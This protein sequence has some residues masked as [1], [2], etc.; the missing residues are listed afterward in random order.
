MRH[1]ST[2]LLGATVAFALLI[3]AAAAAAPTATPTAT[4]D[5]RVLSADQVLEP[6]TSYVVGSERLRTDPEADCNFGGTGGT[7]EVYRFEKPTAFG[8]LRAASRFNGDLRPL[9]VTDEFGFGLA[10]CGVGELD[11]G[12]GTFW[13]LRKNTN[14]ANKGGDIL[15]VRDGDEITLFLSPDQFPD[16]NPGQ[17]T[18]TA[19]A[20]SAPGTFTAHVELTQCVSDPKTFEYVCSTGPAEDVLV[21]GGDADATTDAGGDATIPVAAAGEYGLSASLAPNIPSRVVTVCVHANPSNCPAAH[22]KTI[23]GRDV[24]DVIVDT[25]G[26]DRV[27]ARGGADRIRIRRGGRDEVNCGGGR[28]VVVVDKGDRDDVVF[29]NCER[30]VRR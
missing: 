7:G 27:L 23:V 13:N 4:V 22:G 1:N 29:A 16:P 2:R 30:T 18:L 19:P 24:A 15:R 5:L 20:Y 14:E 9:S 11:D 26:F 12:P 10:L 3:P 25:R 8:L 21:S 6:G 17:L 28:D